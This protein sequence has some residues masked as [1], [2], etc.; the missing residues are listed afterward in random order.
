[1]F[2]LPIICVLCSPLLCQWPLTF[3][4]NTKCTQQIPSR[5]TTQLDLINEQE[6]KFRLQALLCLRC[7]FLKKT[8]LIIVFLSV[9]IYEFCNKSVF[10]TFYQAFI[11]MPAMNLAIKVSNFVKKK[12][13]ILWQLQCGFPLFFLFFCYASTFKINN[14]VKNF[15]W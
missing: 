3:Q 14:A 11:L 15:I 1:M 7:W 12:I 8:R 6:H 10:V 5:F 13:Y 2:L 9:I 4:I